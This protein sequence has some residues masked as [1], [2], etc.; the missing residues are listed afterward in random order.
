MWPRERGNEASEAR[1][2]FP[3]RWEAGPSSCVAADGRRAPARH[4][5]PVRREARVRRFRKA[6]PSFVQPWPLRH[7][8][9]VRLEGREDAWEIWHGDRR[10]V[11]NA[12]GFTL[13][14]LTADHVRK[15]RFA[16]ETER[17]LRGGDPL[18]L[19]RL[20][21]HRWGVA[22][23]RYVNGR[24][25]EMRIYRA[26]PAPF[27]HVCRTMW[28]HRRPPLSCRVCRQGIDAERARWSA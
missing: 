12:S 6:R 7:Y 2:A 20:G 21:W 1:L 11:G 16:D 3:M 8:R 22:W 4:G 25:D 10:V 27:D 17:A 15:E 13:E 19:C 5:P 14:R 23:L 28:V 26:G 9:F 18:D 24:S